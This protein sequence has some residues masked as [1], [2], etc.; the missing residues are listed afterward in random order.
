MDI[1]L[2]VT[3]GILVLIVLLFFVALYMD[4]K[5]YRRMERVCSKVLWLNRAGLQESSIFVSRGVLR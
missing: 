5:E 1:W 4:R 2:S 3:M